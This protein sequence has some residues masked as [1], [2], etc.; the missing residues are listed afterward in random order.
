MMPAIN[1]L[2]LM[3]KNCFCCCVSF[4]NCNCLTK[5]FSSKIH[6]KITGLSKRIKF[7][8]WWKIQHFGGKFHF[9]SK[10][11]QSNLRVTCWLFLL[12]ATS[13]Y[14][15]KLLHHRM[16]LTWI[17]LHSNFYQQLIFNFFFERLHNEWLYATIRFL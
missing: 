7:W 12:Q 8:G 17:L 10:K 11:T 6:E 15:F 1:N 3:A 13:F 4:I 14:T 16:L 2:Q 9:K 5:K